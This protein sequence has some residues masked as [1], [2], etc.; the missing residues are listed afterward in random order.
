MSEKTPPAWEQSD[1]TPILTGNP[2]EFT[3]WHERGTVVEVL[4]LTGLKTTGEIVAA[5]ADTIS[6]LEL[7]RGEPTV[8]YKSSIALVRE[9]WEKTGEQVK[10]KAKRK[11]KRQ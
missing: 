3:A 11:A 1:T 4:N 7:D 10:R 2:P 6:I 9:A 8:I 5:R